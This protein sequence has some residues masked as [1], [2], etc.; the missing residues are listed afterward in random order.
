MPN[1]ENH[2]TEASAACRRSGGLWCWVSLS[3]KQEP[4]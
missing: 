2:L 1:V 4:C 3:P